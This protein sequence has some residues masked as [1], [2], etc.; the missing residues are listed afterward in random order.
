MV[1]LLYCRGLY[2]MR[3]AKK[4]QLNYTKPSPVVYK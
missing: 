2:G 4:L 1:E 3:K